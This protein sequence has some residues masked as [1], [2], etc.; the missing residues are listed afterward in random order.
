MAILA[1]YQSTDINQIYRTDTDQI[2]PYLG[3]V[4]F[5]TLFKKCFLLHVLNYVSMDVYGF[6]FY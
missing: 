6:N 4:L 5:S 1:I 2:V 3:K